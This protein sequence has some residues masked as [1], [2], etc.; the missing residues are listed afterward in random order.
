MKKYLLLLVLFTI[1]FA[2]SSQARRNQG[3]WFMESVV[4]EYGDTIAMVHILPVYKYNRPIDMRRYQRLVNAVKKVYPIAQKAREEMN[5]M[6][7]EMC[8]LPTKADQKKFVREIEK[9]ITAE[10]T[11]VLKK[12]TRFEGRV[13]VK[14]IDRE[15]EYTAYQIVKDFRGGFVAG[16][17]QGIAKLFGHNLKSEYDKDGDDRMIEQV[18]IYYEAGL[19]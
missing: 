15:T 19:L 16:F 6:E 1:G 10:Y 8:R 13:L 18:I 5:R 9:R 12:M 2:M 17:W 4:D 7:D 14:L 11:P 3:Y